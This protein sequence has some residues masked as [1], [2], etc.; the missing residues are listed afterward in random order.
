MKPLDMDPGRSDQPLP[1]HMA[2]R[3]ESQRWHPEDWADLD[4]ADDFDPDA[5]RSDLWKLAAL[6]VGCST[7]V[8][9]GYLVKGCV[10]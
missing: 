2:A 5:P 1:P 7:L 9:I 4:Q 10:G 6:V 3:V 8:G